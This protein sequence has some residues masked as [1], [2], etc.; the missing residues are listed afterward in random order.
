MIK[1]IMNA[2]MARDNPAIEVNVAVPRQITIILR[3]NSSLFRVLT[4][5]YNMVGTMNLPA[6]INNKTI[7]IAFSIEYIMAEDDVPAVP[8]SNG[9]SRTIKMMLR[10][11]NIRILIVTFPFGLSISALS[12][13]IRST[14]A[15]LLKDTKNPRN[16]A[17]PGGC[18]AAIAIK[19]TTTMVR[20]TCIP[21]PSTIVLL[22]FINSF[23]EN[24]I[25]IVNS[26]S[27]TPISANSSII[28]WSFTRPITEGP[29]ITPETRYP[30]IGTIRS[31]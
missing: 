15:V 18:P 10:S 25:P 28:V 5:W 17:I 7:A 26:N 2:P 12:D 23:S 9:T 4:M 14:M 20:S 6:T 22:D 27:M 31:L 16:M 11:W 1:P 30:T 19:V 24:S 21:P 3:R 13:S 8:A 29:I